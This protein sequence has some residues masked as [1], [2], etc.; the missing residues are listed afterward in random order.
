MTPILIIALSILALVSGALTIRTYYQELPRQHTLFK[1]LTTILILV[2]AL[3]APNPVS[4]TYQNVIVAGLVASLIGDVA[5]L[6]SGD[7]W[8]LYGLLS[9][10]GAHVLYIAAFN[11]ASEGSAAW[12]YAIP[13]VVYALLMLFV[14]WPHV[15]ALRV[16]VALY[17]TV[18][19]FMAWQAATRWL[20]DPGALSTQLA[21][22]GAYLFVASDSVLALQ[23]FRGTWRSAPFWVLS[24]YYVA[25]WLI[26]L[27]V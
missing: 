11:L 9:F 7:R 21:L 15:G 1:P 3:V 10:M 20:N 14:L 17:A 16:P 24:T 19:M 8:F 12:Y 23:R 13:F 22:A 5:L 26:A 4:S 27:S 25:Q 18:I 2:I 6:Q